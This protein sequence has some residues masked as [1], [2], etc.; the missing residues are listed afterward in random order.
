MSIRFAAIGLNHNHIYSLT[1]QLLA[2]GA[3]LIWVFAAEPELLAAY[4]AKYPQAVT[5]R[6]VEEIL[7]DESIHLVI[8]AGIPSD[9]APLGIRVM[10]HGK[11]YLCDKPGFTSLQQLEETRH[12][13]TQTGRMYSV[14]FSER[15]S[16][17]AITKAFELVQ[18]G[19]VGKVIHT[20]GLGPHRL[21]IKNRPAWFFQRQHIGGI[22]ND[23]ACHQIDQY[24]L[25]TGS[26]AA[27]IVAAQV[28]NY[29]YPHHP[30]LE[31]FGDLI[32]RGEWCSG[33]IRVDWYTPDGLNTWGDGRLILMG[34]NGYIEV[35]KNCDI[36][37]RTGDGHLFLVD[38]QRTQY[39]DCSAVSLPYGKQFIND[40]LHRTQHTMSQTHC[41]LVCELALKAQLQAQRLGHLQQ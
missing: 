8:S 26:T 5:A 11:D 23:L 6:S 37:G 13:Q 22:L 38:H 29:N 7:E 25:F 4:T 35:R 31:D 30:E 33:Y 27:E 9:H 3:A 21:N 34:E 24:L 28:A 32:L 16:D 19:T 20:T 39:I 36:G 14:Y 17:R 10:Q 1:D 2:E 12:V 40:V 18:S 41:F 15:F